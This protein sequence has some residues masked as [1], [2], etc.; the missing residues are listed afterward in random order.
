MTDTPALQRFECQQLITDRIRAALGSRALVYAGQLVSTA[1]APQGDAVVRVLAGEVTIDRR[2]KRQKIVTESY[3]IAISA[4]NF[5]LPDGN[6]PAE[7]D[8]I[9]LMRSIDESLEDWLPQ[10]AAGAVY[11]ERMQEV[12]PPP[13][14]YD[15]QDA[16][17][18]TTT[19]TFFLK[20]QIVTR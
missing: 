8:A 2:T 14:I 5:Y 17:G 4:R 6:V 20:Y 18:D 19:P 9:E 11:V 16:D 3:V 13:P 10:P 12:T 15:G 7:M 1:D